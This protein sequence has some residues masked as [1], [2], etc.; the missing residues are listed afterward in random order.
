MGKQKHR[1]KKKKAEAMWI[2]DLAEE[3]NLKPLA[4]Q[5]NRVYS[6]PDQEGSR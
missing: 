6:H 3:L 1:I 5:F 4:L 2:G